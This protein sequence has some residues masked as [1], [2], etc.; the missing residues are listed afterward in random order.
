MNRTSNFLTVAVVQVN[1]GENKDRNIETLVTQTEHAAASGA[2][3]V[4]LPE[5]CTYMGPEDGYRTVAEPIPGP[6]VA[7]FADICI[8]RG[9]YI[10]IGSIIEID[11]QTGDLYN[12]SVLLDRTGTLVAKYRKIHLFDVHVAD[13]VLGQ[14]SRFIEAG[15][16]L[17]TAS[18]EGHPA[19]LS[20][21]YDLRFPELYRELALR[22]AEI[23][24]VPAA[25]KMFTGKDH[26]DV[27]L[28]A[29]AIENQ[30]FVVAPA[31]YGNYAGGRNNG[32]SSIIDPWGIALAT[33][34]DGEGF[35]MAKLSFDDLAR[36]R[37]DLPA[38]SHRRIRAGTIARPQ[39]EALSRSRRV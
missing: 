11:E 4:A 8:A 13:Q 19:G 33:V 22:G 1:L 35:A 7:F 32:R 14:E 9:V 29:R 10:L 31:Q 34:P 39:A 23:L 16:D 17:T 12:T 38:L 5:C 2:Q 15:D 24:F 3:V 36:V 26:W 25:F 30:A 18:I 21:C 6:A 20:I 27:L 28:R 37:T